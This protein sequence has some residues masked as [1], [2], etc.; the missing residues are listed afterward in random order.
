MENNKKYYL[1]QLKG[2]TMTILSFVLVIF[3]FVLIGFFEKIGILHEGS[4]DYMIVL[5]VLVPYLIIHEIL[6]CT[7][8]VLHGASFKNITF[9]A[10][11][12]KGVLCCLCKQNISKKNILI[13]LLYPFFFIG[14]CTL[15]IGLFIDD[16]PLVLLSLFNIAG[17]AGDL[18]MFIGL[19]SI[20]NYQY[21]EYDDPTSFGLYTSDN[22]ENHKMFGLRYV[23]VQDSLV[24]E[25]FKKIDINAFSAI[26]LLALMIFGIICIF[27]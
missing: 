12:E 14:I 25:D 5:L 7:S 2:N 4:N 11:L 6:H 20:K 27:I 8:Y 10:H 9:G 23:G 3:G 21:S 24:R 1:Y 18:L 19:V 15:V 17:C 26:V 22:L 16:Y 13:S